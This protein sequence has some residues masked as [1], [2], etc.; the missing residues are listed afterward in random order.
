[1]PDIVF[2]IASALGVGI[3][4]AALLK[5]AGKFVFMR[6][7]AIE[8]ASGNVIKEISAD[9]LLSEDPQELE[10]VRRE[11]HRRVKNGRAPA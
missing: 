1:M 4:L 7:F 5:E 11:I 2:K 10:R 8:D 9:T 6:K 3:P